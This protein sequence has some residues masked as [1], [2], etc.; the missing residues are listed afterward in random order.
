MTTPPIKRHDNCHRRVNLGRIVRGASGCEASPSN[1]RNAR[2][3]HPDAE[4]DGWKASQILSSLS[5]SLPYL[6]VAVLVAKDRV[7]RDR[8]CEDIVTRDTCAKSQEQMPKVGHHPHL[9]TATSL[10][11]DHRVW[12]V[13]YDNQIEKS[14]RAAL[15]IDF[16]L[17]W[18][19][20]SM[21]RAA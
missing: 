8:V 17:V 12:F 7:L 18:T 15:N 13:A 21:E 20:E 5:R 3:L 19:A 6:H 10:A 4:A 2:R 11:S 16:P 1:G 14:E 9:H